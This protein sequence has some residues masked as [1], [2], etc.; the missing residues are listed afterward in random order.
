[1]C[2]VSSVLHCCPIKGDHEV[3]LIKGVRIQQ[4]GASFARGIEQQVVDLILVFQRQTGFG[5]GD[6]VGRAFYLDSI[7]G[8][9]VEGVLGKVTLILFVLQQRQPKQVGRVTE[10]E[11]HGIHH[12][13]LPLVLPCIAE[14]LS[15]ANG[16]TPVRRTFDHHY[17]GHLVGCCGCRTRSIDFV[18]LGH[19]GKLGT[20]E[21][22][23]DFY[24]SVGGHVLVNLGEIAGHG[25]DIELVFSHVIHQGFLAQDAPLLY[26]AS[27][28][29]SPPHLSI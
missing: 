6:T 15:R 8:S 4:V 9:E 27:L 28:V 7:L 11:S 10:E 1:M 18:L 21:F 29:P 12:A 24:L 22:N 14:C 17:K 26:S 19:E 23:V 20:V 5:D 25:A 2:W 13:G 3:A 16:K